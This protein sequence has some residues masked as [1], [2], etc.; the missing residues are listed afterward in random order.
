MADP[1]VVHEDVESAEALDRGVDRPA[2][3]IRFA[4]V[5]ANREH[6]VGREPSGGLVQVLLIATGDHHPR[7]PLDE[8]GGDRQA[9]PAGT[10]V[11]TATVEES[12]GAV[13]V[14]EGVLMPL[15]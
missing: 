1:G 4:D 2:R 7:A 10:P 8:R 12:R 14:G 9:N 6:G 5:G 3:I 11:T 15:E 13:A